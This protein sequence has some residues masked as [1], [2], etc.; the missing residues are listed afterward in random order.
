MKNVVGIPSRGKDFFPRNKIISKIYRRLD[1]GSSVYLAAPRRVGKTSIMRFLEDN[2]QEHYHFIYITT[3]SI[4]EVERY[5]ERLIEEI[6]ESEAIKQVSSKKA[7]IANFVKEVFSKVQKVKFPFLDIEVKGSIK[8]ENF[9]AIFE[10][11]IS[12][13]EKIEDTLVI[14]VDEFPQTVENIRD[15]KG[16]EEAEKFLQLNRQ[17]RQQAAQ[18]IRFIYTGSIGLPAVVKKL[19]S[20]KVINDLNVIEVPPLSVGEA[21][22]LTTKLLGSYKVEFEA[23]TIHYL[24]DTIKWLIPFHIQLAV[25][26]LIDVYEANEQPLKTTDVDKALDQLMNIRNDI[27]FEHYYIRLKDSFPTESYQFAIALLDE[28]A[29]KETLNKEQVAAIANTNQLQGYAAVIESLIY[30]GYIHFD[31]I[32]KIYRFNSYILQRWWSKKKNQ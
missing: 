1:A 23:E 5:Y 27:Y 24:L 4:H 22:T 32:L 16:K 11:L 17:Q 13:F 26:E 30:D 21:V 3:E 6:L 28:L 20:T 29:A 18:N 7:S 12:K 14:M 9:Q 2:P 31:E 10:E 8:Q 25:Q 15:R 19:T